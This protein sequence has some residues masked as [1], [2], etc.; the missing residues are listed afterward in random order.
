MSNDS[1]KYEKKGKCIQKHH[2]PQKTPVNSSSHIPL[3]LTTHT[4][5]HIHTDG[6]TVDMVFSNLFCI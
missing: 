6:T 1:E 3:C 4:R 2:Y 5:A